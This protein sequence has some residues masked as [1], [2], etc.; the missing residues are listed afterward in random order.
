MTASAI[1]ANLPILSRIQLVFMNLSTYIWFYRFFGFNLLSLS[2]LRRSGR[3]SL[4]MII[5]QIQAICRFIYIRQSICSHVILFSP[6]LSARRFISIM[7]H[8]ADDAFLYRFFADYQFSNRSITSI[9]HLVIY[10]GILRKDLLILYLGVLYLFMS[11]LIS[12][13][14]SAMIHEHRLF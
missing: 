5:D 6:N 7:F 12:H 2:Q 1:L 9:G 14:K 8:L 3:T 4:L 13:H 10:V 11:R